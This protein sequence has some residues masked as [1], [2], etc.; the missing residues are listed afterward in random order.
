MFRTIAVN[1]YVYLVIP[2]DIP[3]PL[4]SQSRNPAK[5]ETEKRWHCSLSKGTVSF[6]SSHLFLFFFDIKGE[7]NLMNTVSVDLSDYYVSKGTLCF[8]EQVSRVIYDFGCLFVSFG[9]LGLLAVV[10]LRT[11]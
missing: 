8:T 4:F 3:I 2:K 11:G 10:T 7:P 5:F 9:F 6:C 1:F